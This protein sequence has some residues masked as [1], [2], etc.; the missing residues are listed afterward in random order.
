M[1][2]GNFEILIKVLS[3]NYVLITPKAS[4]GIIKRGSKMRECAYKK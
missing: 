4:L 2:I 3:N 1:E